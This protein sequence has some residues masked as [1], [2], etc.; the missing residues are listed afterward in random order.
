MVQFFTQIYLNTEEKYGKSQRTLKDPGGMCM[1]G[2]C[3]QGTKAE[4]NFKNY[5]AI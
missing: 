1:G 5:Y 4:K 3:A 2:I